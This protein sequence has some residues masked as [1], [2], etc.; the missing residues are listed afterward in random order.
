MS[1]LD[2]IYAIPIRLTLA[3]FLCGQTHK[4]FHFKKSKPTRKRY[5]NL[6]GLMC[7]PPLKSISQM[8]HNQRH[9][10]LRRKPIMHEQISVTD[11]IYAIPVR[12]TL[13]L[14]SC[15]DKLAS[16]FTL[17]NRNPNSKEIRKFVGLMCAPPLKS[18]SQ[19]RLN[20]MCHKNSKESDAPPTPK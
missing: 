8:R 3:F 10:K 17:K 6:V 16:R 15:A 4:P 20:Q 14:S 19:M 13:P 9:F 11:D 12:L 18:I 2:D 7:A 5:A 1:E